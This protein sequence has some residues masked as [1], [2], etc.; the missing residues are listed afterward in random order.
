MTESK[1][2]KK[3]MAWIYLL[4][5]PLVLAIFLLQDGMLL[6]SLSLQ[7]ALSNASS[8]L[9][10]VDSIPSLLDQ[11]GAAAERTG[12]GAANLYEAAESRLSGALQ[13]LQDATRTDPATQAKYQR[14]EKLVNAQT[15]NWK[16]AIDSRTNGRPGAAD[17]VGPNQK[18]MPEIDETLSEIRGGQEAYLG[19]KSGAAMN[20]LRETANFFK[21]GGALVLWIVVAVT[22]LLFY[23]QKTRSSADI[24][25]KQKPASEKPSEKF[26]VN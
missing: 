25:V 17:G 20:S 9:D 8:T 18:W 13:V 16:Q 19:G 4:A 14:L 12:T 24:V 22:M 1:N 6:R 15:N 3:G 23:A 7:A 21:F 26:S 11:A 2:L 10:H 5:I